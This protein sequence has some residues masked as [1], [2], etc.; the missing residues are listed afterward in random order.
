MRQAAEPFDD[1]GALAS[2]HEPFARLLERNGRP[3]D[4]RRPATF[5]TLVRLILEQQ[6]SLQSAS[7][8]F[9]RLERRVGKVTPGAVVSLSDEQLRADGF[10]RQKAR[11]VKG[12]AQLL[13][14]GALDLKAVASLDADD[15]VARLTAIRGV[16][17]WT[18]SCFAL[19]VNGAADVWPRGDRALHVSMTRVM[20]LD[21][22]PSSNAAASIAAAW[23][24]HRSTA[25][26]MLWHEY[27]GGASW[28]P[29]DTAGFIEG[30]GMV[31]S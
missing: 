1:A 2:N 29:P 3:P 21:D 24:P 14:E 18:A 22:V 8:A 16:G 28:R 25:A 19:F 5:E 7:A 31:P 15:A 6:V 26:R 20:G 12:V 13:I 23:S 9:G 27:L 11:Y 10:S 30:A 4:L 17:P